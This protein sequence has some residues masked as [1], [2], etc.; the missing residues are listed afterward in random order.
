MD[1]GLTV[2]PQGDGLVLRRM[3]LED[4]EAAEQVSALAFDEHRQDGSPGRDAERRELWNVRTARAVQEDG[5]GCWV[6]ERDGEVLGVATSIRRDTLWALSTWAVLPQW[7]GR[8]TGRPLLEASLSYA[9]GTLRRMVSSSADPNAVRHYIRVGFDLHPQ[10]T[11]HGQVDAVDLPRVD[12][13]RDGHRSDLEWMTS[14]VRQ[15]RGAAHSASDH[16]LLGAAG[17]LRVVDRAGRR[18]FAHLTHD[19]SIALLAASDRRTANDLFVDA[20]V[21]RHGQPF[22][23]SHVTG[24]NQWALRTATAAGL[25]VSTQ[26]YLGVAGLRPPQA[27][28]HHGTLL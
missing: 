22:T 5:P 25:Q 28:V 12:R 15:A 14:L 26:G 27:Y 20:L 7:R 18:G 16:E 11:L 24:A 23:Q 13:V 2:Q 21:Q 19:G 3:R 6:M 4:V 10:M 8:G 9:S 1:A 17:D